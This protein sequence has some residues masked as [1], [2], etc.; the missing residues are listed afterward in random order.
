MWPTMP[1]ERCFLLLHGF[2]NHR[3]PEHWQ[4]W[5]AGE[6]RSIGVPVIYPQLPDPDRPTYDAWATALITHLGELAATG[7]GERIVLC[8][9]L[10]SVMWLRAAAQGQILESLRPDRLVLVSPPA[11]DRVPPAAVGFAPGIPDGDALRASVTTEIRFV[12]SEGDDYNPEGVETTYAEPLGLPFDLI[13]G[14]GHIS[15]ADGFGPWPAMLAWCQAPGG[16]IASAI[17]P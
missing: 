7:A 9:S 16:P 13:A 17:T 4:H 3:P 5:L 10:S 11:P 1:A 12:G 15:A 14:A 6:L 8:H 2:G